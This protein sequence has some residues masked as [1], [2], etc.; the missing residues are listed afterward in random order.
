MHILVLVVLCVICSLQQ[1]F[2]VTIEAIFIGGC[3]CKKLF[4]ICGSLN[5]VLFIANNMTTFETH[6]NMSNIFLFYEKGLFLKVEK[7]MI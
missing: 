2:E 1:C 7:S 4:E 3:L 6:D 5:C